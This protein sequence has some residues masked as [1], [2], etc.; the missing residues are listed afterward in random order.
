MSYLILVLSQFKS[1][2]KMLL[3]LTLGVIL[4]VLAAAGRPHADEH[5]KAQMQ[6][7]T[8]LKLLKDKS[9]NTATNHAKANI[10]STMAAY[11]GHEGAL[12]HTSFSCKNS[13][14]VQKFLRLAKHFYRLA[15]ARHHVAAQFNIAVMMVNGKGIKCDLE[16]ALVLILIAKQNT[17]LNRNARLL[18]NKFQTAIEGLLNTDQISRTE[19]Q[20]AKLFGTRIQRDLKPNLQF[21]NKPCDAA[22]GHS[23]NQSCC[24]AEKKTAGNSLLEGDE[25]DIFQ[26]PYCTPVCWV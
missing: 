23:L 12:F 3:I 19:W 26:H 7:M 16:K 24:L 9:Q 15:A 5:T 6:Y 25:Y 11:Y 2:Y 4:L 8:G 10:R 20:A 18:L 1:H 17:R 13:P 21:L 14:D 22:M